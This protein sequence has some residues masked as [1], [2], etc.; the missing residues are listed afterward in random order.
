MYRVSAVADGLLGKAGETLRRVWG[1]ESFRPLQQEAVTAALA[2]RDSLVVLP[3]GGGKSLCFQVPALCLDGLAVVVSP[4]ISLMKD[5]V[6]ALQA[7][8]VSAAFLNST[9]GAEEQ[10]HIAQQI[11]DGQLKLLYV[12]PERLLTDRMLDFLRGT[13]LSLFAIDEAHCISDWGHDFRPEYRGLRTLKDRFPQIPVHAY[14]A[15]AAEQVRKDIV[16]Q[17]GLNDAE[18]LV[19]SFDR[20]NLVYRML[21]VDG[22]MQQILDVV[23]RHRGESGIVYCISRKEVERVTGALS[24]LGIQAVSYHA[25]M[26]E[27]ARRRNQEAFI[28]DQADV[29][30]AT[31]AFGMGIDKPDVRYVV[32]AGMPK[33]IE[34]YQQ[35]SGR[36]GRDGLE[37]ECVLLYSAADLITWKK[38]LSSLEAPARDG[39]LRALNA[40]HNLCTSAVC[41]HR[42]LSAY[43]GQQ[44]PGDNC[45][46]C[47][48][49][50]GEVDQADDPVT[51]G[52]MILSC[53]LRLDER[54]G[55]DHTAKVLI[56]SSDQRVLQLGHDRLSTYGLLKEHA[57]A[58]VRGW[59]EQLL[60]QQYLV[61]DGEHQTLRVTAS[62][63]RVLRRQATPALSRP[64]ERKASAP[65]HTAADHQSW[66]GVDRGLFE[67][68]KQVRLRLAQE[69]KVPAY[70]IFGDATLR[71]L[72]KVRP[73]TSDRLRLIRGIGQQKLQDF[74]ETF[75]EALDNYC[76]NVGLDRD[77]RSVNTAESEPAPAQLKLPGVGAG[78]LASLDYFRQ[79]MS[80][81][82]VAEKMG[83]ARSTV[84]GY[85]CEYLRHDRV[86]DP[87]PWVG[88]ELLPAI[89]DALATSSDGRLK[90]IFEQLEGKASYDEIR[91]VLTCRQ[92]RLAATQAAQ[93]M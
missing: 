18:I 82:A 59:I 3:T 20:P 9:Q 53:V 10:R 46:A 17:L 39:S 86:T 21:P 77:C 81:E 27:D 76:G 84:T 87:S 91:I 70:V 2:G 65:R 29:V 6:D 49:C 5:Q 67:H 79:Q 47:D 60:S 68:L 80:I 92:N 48:V 25:G 36:A 23:S 62:G 74:G 32:H 69:R 28:R 43:F 93:A 35:E 19:G 54:F 58:T 7:C 88:A 83:R 64:M 37:S 72:A 12:A 42:A 22:R 8:G 30:V 66:V 73:S 4:L 44:L 55:A 51:L 63:M 56:G 15:T 33:S 14:T 26:E 52:Q 13:P 90:P 40:M 31:V 45:G 61:R 11:R 41:R 50:L 85:L 89:E 38:M 1:Y 16:K 75:L 24:H 34:H 78:A 71:E 57:L